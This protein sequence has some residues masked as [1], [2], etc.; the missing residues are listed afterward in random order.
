M[1]VGAHVYNTSING[2]RFDVWEHS[3]RG[4]HIE[5]EVDPASGRRRRVAIGGGARLSRGAENLLTA[6]YPGPGGSSWIARAKDH[7]STST[8]T[9]TVRCITAEIAD[10]DVYVA[11]HVDTKNTGIAGAPARLPKEYALIG[12]GAQ[13]YFEKPNP[14]YPGS[15]MLYSWQVARSGRPTTGWS[16]PR[17]VVSTYAIGLSRDLL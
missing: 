16:R 8:A 9:L 12:G 11:Q 3:A 14:P 1:T 15:L 17:I 2:I 13:L 5:V 4:R 10:E 7:L 6:I